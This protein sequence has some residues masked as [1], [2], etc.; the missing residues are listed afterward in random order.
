MRILVTFAVEAEFAP[1]RARRQFV[2]QSAE[3]LKLWKS[4]IGSSEIF[5][6]LTG[7]GDNTANVMELIL[8]VAGSDRNF[9]VCIS[10]GLAGALRSDYKLSDIVVGKILKS[11]AIHADLGRDW[12]EADKQLVELAVAHGAKTAEAFYTVQKVLT[13]AQ[14]KSVL[15]TKA[16][17]VEM[18][19]FDVVKEG[20]AWGARGVAIRAISD[21]A[22]EDLPIDF[23]RTISSNN[24]VSVPRVLAEVVR[25]PG[26]LGP[27]IRF[28]KQSRNAAEALARFLE[29]YL[30][31]LVEVVATQDAL[32]VA[33]R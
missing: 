6:V 8:R 28:G 29:A 2:P 26:T 5:V 9:D 14:Q 16:D 3:G 20:Y 12:L 31:K 22:D 30:P 25:N 21:R 19:S 11:S 32:K 18:E 15:A 17:V 27:L 24:Q 10:S 33:A 7:I 13:T 23:N 4:A 1:W